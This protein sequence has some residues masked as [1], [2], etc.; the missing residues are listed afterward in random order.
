MPLRSNMK[1]QKKYFSLALISTVFISSC[2]TGESFQS[3]MSRYQANAKQS[4]PVPDIKVATMTFKNQKS[5]SPASVDNTTSKSTDG[6]IT[7]KKLYFL[8]LIDQYE[9]LKKFSDHYA[10]PRVSICPNF[11][12]GLLNHY[13]KYSV[14]DKKIVHPF[15]YEMSSITQDEYVERHPELYL[16]VTKESNLPRVIDII[17]SKNITSNA[18]VSDLVKNA[19]DIHLTKTYHE[20]AELCEYGTSDNYYIYEN[21]VTHVKSSDFSPSKENMNI[22]LK[23]TLFSNL[24]ILSSLEFQKEKSGRSIA[25]INEVKTDHYSEELIGKMNVEWSKEYFKNLN[26]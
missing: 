23:T 14:S 9:T 8:T 4:S 25:S 22:L 12:T 26:N 2:S 6:S 17:K 3:K 11:H 20:I 1:N 13:E 5:R 19:V 10:A 15:K 16:P 18:D 7:N 21:L 24:A